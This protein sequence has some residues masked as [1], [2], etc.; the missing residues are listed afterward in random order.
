MPIFEY[1]CQRC[2]KTFESFS[3]RASAIRPP[4]CPAC[5]SKDAERIFSVFAGRVAGNGGCGTTASGGG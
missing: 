4:V 5:G 1:K 2:G 3:Q